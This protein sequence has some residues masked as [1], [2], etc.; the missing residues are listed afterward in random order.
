M[1]SL[2][3]FLNHGTLPFIGR[4]HEIERLTG[5]WRG[6]YQAT[7]LRAMLL[8]G[9][10]GVG[11]S[12]LLGEVIARIVAA[13]GSVVHVKLYPEATASFLSLVAHALWHPDAG[14]SI[15]AA[16]PEAEFAMVG[17]A[18]Q[19]LARLRPTIIVVEDI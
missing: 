5:F 1:H 8:T 11:K 14:R 16:E 6:V 19:R 13:G 3:D 9:E 10:A 4:A 2:T 17:V 18:L 12:R 7:E 15:L